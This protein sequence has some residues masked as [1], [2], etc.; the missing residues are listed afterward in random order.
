MPHVTFN[1]FFSGAEDAANNTDTLVGFLTEHVESD[2][3]RLIAFDG[4]GITHGLSGII[5]GT[6]LD[7]HC[8]K[9]IEQIAAEIKKGNTVSLNAYGHSRGATG[10]LL[11]AKQLSTVEKNLLEI[12]LALLDPTPGNLITSATL[13]FLGISLANKTKDL[14]NC[15]PLSNVLALYPNVPLP[16]IT[17]RAPSF[18]LYPE[19]TKVEEEAIAGYHAQT[20]H[21][22]INPSGVVFSPESFITFARVVKFLQE[23]GTQFKPFPSIRV[24][25]MLD[26]KVDSNRLDDALLAVYQKVN[27]LHHDKTYRNCH[28]DHGVIINTKEKAEY[29]NLHHQYLAGKSKK[30]DSARV[31]LEES[32][33]LAAVLRRTVHNYPKMWQMIKWVSISLIIAFLIFT[34]I[35]SAGISTPLTPLIAITLAPAASAGLAGLWYS[36]LKPA[37]DWLIDRIFYP[38][39]YLRDITVERV[40]I[41]DSTKK[42][43]SSLGVDKNR[44]NQMELEITPQSAHEPLDNSSREEELQIEDAITQEINTGLNL[45]VSH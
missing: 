29:F 10:L 1:V 26:L 2:A 37:I 21:L 4:C 38:H 18:S 11:L 8:Q 3:Q 32:Y 31:T 30:K 41:E 25:G 20:Q 22:T 19:R 39:F 44:E 42:M 16:A 12:N 7:Q 43:A 45:N 40:P 27:E 24:E 5:F 36:L 35:T 17:L 14:R 13:D 15:L 33:S 34:I 9:V 6:G 23:N 28:S